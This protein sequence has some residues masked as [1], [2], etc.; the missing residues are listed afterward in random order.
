LD[1]LDEGYW[2]DLII[3][4]M[5]SINDDISS[6]PLSWELSED[7]KEAIGRFLWILVESI[8]GSGKEASALNIQELVRLT[9]IRELHFTIQSICR[10]IFEYIVPGED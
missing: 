5:L 7:I 3:G 6:A 1:G 4:K 9:P 2:N 10:E 8:L